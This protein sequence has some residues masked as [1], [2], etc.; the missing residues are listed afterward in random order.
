MARYTMGRQYE[1]SSLQESIHPETSSLSRFVSEAFQ[2]EN[3]SNLL[4]MYW[5]N[6]IP[7]RIATPLRQL[8]QTLP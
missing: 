7:G 8:G 2:G 1:V 6:F 4:L 5:F 3:L